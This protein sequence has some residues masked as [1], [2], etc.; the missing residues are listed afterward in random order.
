MRP[1]GDTSRKYVKVDSDGRA[2]STG[3]R[4][5]SVARVWVWRTPPDDEAVVT[6]NGQT[7]STFFGGH[8]AQ[9]YTLLAPLFKTNSAG[10]YSVA[11]QVNG[12]GISGQA[13]A[14]RLGIATALQGLDISLRPALKQAGFLTR[15]A[16]VRERKKPGQAGARK[17]FAW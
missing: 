6:V 16:K 8:W 5:S 4:K 2:Y 3:R 1:P 15:N 14:V 17:K 7:I 10:M 9:R 12:G 11:A 13:E